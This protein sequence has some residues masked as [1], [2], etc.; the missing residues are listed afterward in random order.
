MSSKPRRAVIA[1]LGITPASSIVNLPGMCETFGRLYRNVLGVESAL[2]VYESGGI[3]PIAFFERVG[4]LANG[5]H[6]ARSIRTKHIRKLRLNAEHLGEASFAL[7]CVPDAHPR[8]LDSDQHFIWLD[9]GNG[10]H[11][12]ID[13]FDAAKAVDRG[14]AHGFLY[15]F[16][17][18]LLL[19]TFVFSL[20]IQNI[21]DLRQ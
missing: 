21:L 19:F 5:G 13:F 8:R 12:Q 7:E 15:R 10:Q 16:C 1:S 14:C 3:N 6:R 4:L 9:L 20:D 11:L 18:S 2:R 17:H